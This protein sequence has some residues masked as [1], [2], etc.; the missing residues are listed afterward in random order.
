VTLPFPQRD[1]P[2]R[3]DTAR[4]QRSAYPAHPSAPLAR[5]RAFQPADNGE[6]DRRPLRCHRRRGARRLRRTFVSAEQPA[7]LA[8]QQERERHHG[9]ADAQ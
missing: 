7:I 9:A 5:R 6:W 2:Q 3:A 1:R 8:G 4:R